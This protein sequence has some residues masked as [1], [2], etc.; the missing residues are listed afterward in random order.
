MWVQWS[1]LERVGRRKSFEA[2]EL[3]LHTLLESSQCTSLGNELELRKSDEN[4]I[5]GGKVMK[6]TSRAS[7]EDINQFS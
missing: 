1:I 4:T 6:D 5:R 7:V 2:V 3:S